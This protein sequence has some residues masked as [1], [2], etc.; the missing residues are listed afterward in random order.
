MTRRVDTHNPPLQKPVNKKTSGSIR[1]LFGVD[2]LG[3]LGL[4]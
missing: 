1:H 2:F 4:I 3:R